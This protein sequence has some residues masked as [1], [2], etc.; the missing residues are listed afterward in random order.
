LNKPKRRRP[1]GAIE[2]RSQ[3][4]A[5]CEQRVR[6]ALAKLVKTGAP[7][8]VEAVCTLAGVGKTFVYDKRHP[9]LTTAVLAARDAS[10]R[11][12]TARAED[13]LDQHTVSWRERAAIA[14]ALCKDLKTVIKDRDDRIADLIGQLYD[15]QGTHLADENADLRQV[16][17]QLTRKLHESMIETG[18]LRRTLEASRAN[19][20]RERERNVQQLISAPFGVQTT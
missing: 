5:A 6:K 2:K 7:F 10:H 14:E 17:A 11:T 4:S 16:V 15:P 8:T 18:K 12:A 9:E 20:K 1:V 13:K 19:V 3:T